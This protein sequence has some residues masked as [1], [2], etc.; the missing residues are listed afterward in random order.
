MTLKRGHGFGTPIIV[1][2]CYTVGKL[3]IILKHF[4]LVGIIPSVGNMWI[5]FEHI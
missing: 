3:Q 4:Y 1:F 2:V 5:N